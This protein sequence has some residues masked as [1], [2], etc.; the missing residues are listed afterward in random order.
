MDIAKVSQRGQLVLPNDIR[1]R[2][3]LKEG[4]KV[5]FF[6]ENGRVV[7]ENAAMLSVRKA[8]AD[9]EGEANRAGLTTK[10]DV[11]KLMKE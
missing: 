9:F 6:E 5:V 2:L 11:V 7:V 3:K 4:D 8:Q 1:K 10:Q